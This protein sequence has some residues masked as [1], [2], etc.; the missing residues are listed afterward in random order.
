[1]TNIMRKNRSWLGY[2]FRCLVF[3][4]KKGVRRFKR[5]W[6]NLTHKETRRKA[7]KT[8]YF[9]LKKNLLIVSFWFSLYQTFLE[10]GWRRE[11]ENERYKYE[12]ATDKV[13][14]GQR[15][16]IKFLQGAI[17]SKDTGMKNSP[18]ARWKAK[19]T[20]EGWRLT[21][22]NSTF[23]T[24][25]NQQRW[26]IVGKTYEEVYGIEFSEAYEANNEIAVQMGGRLHDTIQFFPFDKNKGLYTGEW[27][28]LD[29]NDEMVLEGFAIPLEPLVEEIDG[30]YKYEVIIIE[31]EGKNSVVDTLNISK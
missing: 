11:A 29:N 9:W 31:V 21:N 13:V 26:H 1:M 6:Y 24:L 14:Y 23:E 4:H 2:R 30:S 22:V 20:K 16:T 25:F 8:I 27:A 10:R 12:I 3:Q 18:I 5:F 19:K 28:Y 15:Q 7:L 17:E